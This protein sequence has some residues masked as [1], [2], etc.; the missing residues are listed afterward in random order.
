M[1]ESLHVEGKKSAGKNCIIF[2]KME[3]K[4][5]KLITFEGPEGSGKSTQI[6]F[7]GDCLKIKNYGVLSLREPGGTHVGEA[8]RGIIQHNSAGESPEVIAEL[9]LFE[10]ARAQLVKKRII[11]ALEAGN[12]VLCDRFYDS[13]TAYQG[14][15]RGLDLNMINQLNNIAIQN[16]VPDLTF[17]LDLPIDAGFSRINRQGRELDRMEKEERSFHERVRNGYLDIA[18]K[19]P[20]RFYILK[21][22][23]DKQTIA[24]EI[25]T[26]SYE[27]LDL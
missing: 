13:T 19:N 20:G 1:Q 25:K 24:E 17:L 26:A 7:L 4:R 11:P 14:Y 12:V 18:E 22:D 10:V 27:R 6:A 3:T 5:G 16:C 2:N 21:A 8:V 9:L 23:Q 15:G